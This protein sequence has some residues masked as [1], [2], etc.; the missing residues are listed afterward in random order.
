[1]QSA[2][3]Q[4]TISLPSQ[5][6]ISTNSSSKMFSIRYILSI[7]SLVQKVNANNAFEVDLKCLDNIKEYVGS[8]PASTKWLRSGEVIGAGAKVYGFRVDNVHHETYRLLNGMS[9]GNQ[10]A[11]EIQEENGQKADG[12]ENGE[13][14]D[15]QENKKKGQK[16]KFH[17]NE[18]MNNAEDYLNNFDKYGVKTLEKETNLNLASFDTQHLVDPLFKKTTRMFDEMS[19]ST[20]MSSTLET[21][22]NLIL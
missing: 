4:T 19:L 20:L 10:T 15:Q 7:I 1:M 16:V 13:I 18:E 17:G 22:P 8:L 12:E 9:R 6:T 21:S 11:D 14:L 5:D 2:S 3:R